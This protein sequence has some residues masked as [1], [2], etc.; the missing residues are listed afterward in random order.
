MKKWKIEHVSK[1]CLSKNSHTIEKGITILVK[2]WYDCH[3]QMHFF[4][5]WNIEVCKRNIIFLNEW[6]CRGV[7]KCRFVCPRKKKGEN[8]DLHNQI[9]IYVDNFQRKR[10]QSS[11]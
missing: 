10:G 4:R 6:A 5:P 8:L 3:I 2:I 7:Q 11:I 1:S 9:K